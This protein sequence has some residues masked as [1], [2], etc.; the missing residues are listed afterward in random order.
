[1]DH[2]ESTR[3]MLVVSLDQIIT[4]LS[5]FA[6]GLVVYKLYGPYIFALL[7]LMIYILFKLYNAKV[8]LSDRIK[9]ELESEDDEE[10]ESEIEERVINTDNEEGIIE[11]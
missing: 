7:L 9:K 11:T 2:I 8:Q 4:F 5:A 1:M 10:S 3:M 6:I